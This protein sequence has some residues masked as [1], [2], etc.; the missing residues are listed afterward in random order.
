MSSM[1][2]QY[3]GL[4]NSPD[5]P[6]SLSFHILAHRILWLQQL[7]KANPHTGML[8]NYSVLVPHPRHQGHACHCLP[9]PQG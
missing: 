6:I 5:N 9:L 4:P 3:M 7:A 1:R 2:T 8:D